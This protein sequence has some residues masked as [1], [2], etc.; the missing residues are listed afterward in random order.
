M[1]CFKDMFQWSFAKLTMVF[2]IAK[3]QK[4]CFYGGLITIMY[5]HLVRAKPWLIL[6]RVLQ[7]YI[8]LKELVH[9]KM[10]I[11]SP[12][13]HPRSSC[14]SFFSVKVFLRKHFRVFLQTMNFNRNQNVLLHNK[15]PKCFFFVQMTTLSKRFL[16]AQIHE[17][18]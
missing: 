11:Y 3:V 5:Y 14:L 17:N 10:K 15:K 2:I 1:S 7:I 18:D 4:P 13:C 12:Q 16:F 9:L 6:A 8:T